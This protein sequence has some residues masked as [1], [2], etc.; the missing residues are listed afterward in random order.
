MAETEEKAK[1]DSAKTGDGIVVVDP[2]PMKGLTSRMI[3]YLEKLVVK[4]LYDS[5][6][7]QH[8]LSGN[9]API[10]DETPPVPELHVKGHLPVSSYNPYLPPTPLRCSINRRKLS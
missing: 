5:S 10:P 1:Y 8:Y 2:K 3:D 6:Q 7:P 9:F 4:L